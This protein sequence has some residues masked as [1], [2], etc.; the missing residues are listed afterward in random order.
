[1]G[2]GNKNKKKICKKSYAGLESLCDIALRAIRLR[3]AEL[4]T[5]VSCKGYVWQK[6][7]LKSIP[8]S[9][10]F[11]G[12]SKKWE[13]EDNP[14][15]IRPCKYNKERGFCS[16]IFPNGTGKP[17]N[18]MADMPE[19]ICPFPSKPFQAGGV[20]SHNVNK[21]EVVV[22]PDKGEVVLHNA[23]SYPAKVTIN[24]GK[25]IFTCKYYDRVSRLVY[26][27]EFEKLINKDS[28]R[29]VINYTEYA[30]EG[31]DMM[32]GEDLRTNF[33]EFILSHL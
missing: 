33:T 30:G 16:V 9:G 1:M 21:G 6:F 10:R 22:N 31:I 28:S 2:K 8:V 20:V 5:R 4:T 14:S 25:K 19:K 13:T 29:A 27:K 24:P 26:K 12:Y 7:N 23:K 15:G 17:Y 32:D 11:F 3:E 18:G